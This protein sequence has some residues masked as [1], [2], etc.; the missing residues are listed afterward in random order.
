MADPKDVLARLQPLIDEGLNHVII[1]SAAAAAAA[2]KPR[3]AA[4]HL[5]EQRRLIRMLKNST[6]G[7][8][9]P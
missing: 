4:H 7:R 1:Y 6:P 9:N 8:F 3:L 2:L 5:Y